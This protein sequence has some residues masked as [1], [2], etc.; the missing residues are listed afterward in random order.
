M[1][2]LI[3]FVRE[4]HML[5]S[6]ELGKK[7][8]LQITGCWLVCSKWSTSQIVVPKFRWCPPTRLPFGRQ[9]G[10]QLFDPSWNIHH[11]IQSKRRAEHVNCLAHGIWGSMCCQT[12]H[13][14]NFA[15][16]F[17]IVQLIV[18]LAHC[19]PRHHCQFACIH[20]CCDQTLLSNVQNVM[21]NMQ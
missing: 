12:Y 16:P 14:L 7:N 9:F 13:K 10:W 20:I 18:T 21:E 17:A 1:N 4:R 2:F 3:E 11:C 8:R 19:V 5:Q 6:V 15:R